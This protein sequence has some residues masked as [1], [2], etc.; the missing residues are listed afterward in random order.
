MSFKKYSKTL[1]VIV[2]ALTL[3]TGCSQSTA[4]V[5][6][7]DPVPVVVKNIELSSIKNEIT[8]AGRVT[9]SQTVAVISKVSGKVS[10]TYFD[11]G[12]KV[13]KDDVLFKLDEKDINN[14]IAQIETQMAVASQSVRAA[15]SGLT[16]ATGGQFDAQVIQ[17]EASVSSAEKQLENAQIAMENAQNTVKNAQASY[18]LALEALNNAKTTYDSMKVLYDAG[19]ISKNDF[20]KTELAYKQADATY[21]QALVGKDQAELADSQAKV[22]YAQAQAGLKSARES[23]NISTGKVASETRE[24]ASIGVDQAVASRDS[25]ALQ[26]EIAKDTLSD[27][28]VRSPINGVVISKNAKIGEFTSSQQPAYTIADLDTVNVEVKVTEVIINRLQP[29]DV[30]DVYIKTL[31]NDPFKGKLLTVSPAADQT[32]MYPVKIQLQNPDGLIKGGMFA[33]VRFVKEMSESAVIMPRNSVFEDDMGSYLYVVQDDTAK[34]TSVITG[35]DNGREIE[36]V[37]GLNGSELVIITGQSFVS[38][39]EKILITGQEEASG[40]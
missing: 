28:S 36:I 31:G 5:K 24:K 15:Q 8:Y 4:E 27:T 20:E 10:D 34:K 25:T 39:G 7:P 23:Y 29:G 38:D 12:D 30:V 16:S 18:E 1:P 35:I 21:K 37:S 3:I 11:I 14:Q 22:T 26:L 17:L 6:E 13:I 32:N 40:R 9:P 33:E 2:M 19:T